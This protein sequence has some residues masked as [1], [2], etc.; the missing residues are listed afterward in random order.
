MTLVHQTTDRFGAI[1]V[2]ETNGLRTLQFGNHIRQS[3]LDREHP[4]RLAMHSSRRLV[5]GLLF[6]PVPNRILLLGL[7]GGVLARYFLK[8]FPGIQ[9]TAIEKRSM[10]VRV[11]HDY[12]DL[13][14]EHPRLDIRVDDAYRFLKK[15][16]RIGQRYDLVVV[17]L[18][19]AHGADQILSNRQ[20]GKF[21]SLAYGSLAAK[22]ALT[23]NFWRR[24]FPRYFAPGTPF[25]HA[26]PGRQSL[27]MPTPIGNV[28]LLGLHSGVIRTGHIQ[29]LRLERKKLLERIPALRPLTVEMMAYNPHFFSKK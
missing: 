8:Y 6:Q 15:N 23:C 2:H 12:F 16:Q 27:Q 20:A 21:F 26:F 11:A 10:V 29:P 7:G 5:A 14:E 24:E 17:D 9:I 1:E 4:E 22:G 18:F 19:G 25:R 28:V 3:A 13:P